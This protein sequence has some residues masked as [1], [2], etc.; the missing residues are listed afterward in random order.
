M[1]LI[2]HI[3]MALRTIFPF[4]MLIIDLS[5]RSHSDW[6][7]E[8]LCREALLESLGL[9]MLLSA[10]TYTHIEAA[11]NFTKMSWSPSSDTCTFRGTGGHRD[12][13]DGSTVHLASRQAHLPLFDARENL[14]AEQRNNPSRNHWI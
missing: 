14:S 9:P 4:P 6:Q 5:F 13:I 10:T 1:T 8:T 3:L 11:W 12:H 7:S 2:F